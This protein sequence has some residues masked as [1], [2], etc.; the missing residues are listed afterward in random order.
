VSCELHSARAYVPI[1]TK[2]LQER[3]KNQRTKG[4]RALSAVDRGAA[5]PQHSKY[6]YTQYARSGGGVR[7]WRQC[8][9]LASHLTA[10]TGDLQPGHL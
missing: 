8:D 4:R 7:T 9:T 5:R 2:M 1:R 10:N 3:K 6:S